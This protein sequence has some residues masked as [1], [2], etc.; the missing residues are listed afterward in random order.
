MKKNLVLLTPLPQLRFT[1]KLRGERR[2]TVDDTMFIQPLRPR[3]RRAMLNLAKARDAS[4][5]VRML[6]NESELVFVHQVPAEWQVSKITPSRAWLYSPIASEILS[7]LHDCFLLFTWVPVPLLDPCWFCAETS[8]EYGAITLIE[9]LHPHWEY[10]HQFTNVDWRSPDAPPVDV[11]LGRFSDDKHC[12]VPYWGEVLRYSCGIDKVESLGYEPNK[13]TRLFKSTGEYAKRKLH[14]FAKDTWGPDAKVDWSDLGPRHKS[15]DLMKYY[16]RFLWEGYRSVLARELDKASDKL[17]RNPYKDRLGRAFQFFTQSFRLV[18]PFRFV[19]FATCLETLLCTGR[20]EITF[21]LAARL[22][23]LLEPKEYDKRRDI[24]KE[25]TKLYGLRS[26]IV[27]GAEF[28]VDKIADQEGRLVDLCR[29]A[30]LK[31]LSNDSLCATF[32]NGDP[33][34]CDAYLESLNLGCPET[35]S[36]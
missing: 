22:G 7:R 19:A 5:D 34:V 32:Q 14:D 9:L 26:T 3:L 28:S 6:V 24:F 21:Q 36:V 30:L 10:V 16:H 15:S 20:M 2:F 4:D 33:K 35:G 25:A 11:D 12:R 1:G 18:E 29:R 27:H 23:W 17:H 31:I 8:A 13:L